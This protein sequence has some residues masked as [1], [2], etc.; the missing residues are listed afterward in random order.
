MNL[1][2]FGISYI[3]L[4]KFISYEMKMYILDVNSIL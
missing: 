2:L 4:L 3:Q 1:R